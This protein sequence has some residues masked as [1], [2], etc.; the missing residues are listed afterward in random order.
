M[1]K[2]RV[3]TFSMIGIVFLLLIFVGVSAGLTRLRSQPPRANHKALITKLDYCSAEDKNPCIV[4]F[5]QDDTGDMLV[6]LF[7]PSPSFPKFYLVV[8]RENKEIRYQCKKVKDYPNSALCKGPAMLPGETL[9][10]TL[11][12]TR[13]STVL[14]EGSFAII[15]LMLATPESATT[16]V[17]GT[18]ETIPAESL[19]PSLLEILTPLPTI[20]SYPNPSYPNP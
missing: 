1:T 12:A 4:S 18:I 2:N 11:I 7:I 10:F 5:S 14:A 19:T 20:P 13:D 16:E 6:N 8:S 17:A 15:G 3:I 9:Q